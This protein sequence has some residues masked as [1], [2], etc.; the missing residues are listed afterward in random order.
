MNP[1]GL[2]G[3]LK[4]DYQYSITR[5]C[6]DSSHFRFVLDNETKKRSLVSSIDFIFIILV[7][8]KSVKVQVGVISMRNNLFF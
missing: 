4:R 8:M 5:L 7:L 6:S 2:V 3:K 1:D